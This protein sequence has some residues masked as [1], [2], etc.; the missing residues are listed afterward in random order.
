M[1]L[2]TEGD[3]HHVT[4]PLHRDVRIGTLDEII[5]DMAAFLGLAKQ[6]VRDTLFG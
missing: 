1:T 5:A 4:V 2:T 6:A 3:Q